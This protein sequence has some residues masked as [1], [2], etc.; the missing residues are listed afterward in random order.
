MDTQRKRVPQIVLPRG[1]GGRIT[2]VL[3]NRMHGDIY[4]IVAP[5]LALKPDDYLLE[6]ACGNG[7]FLKKHASHVRR[8]AGL[9]HS[10]LA[11]ETAIRNNKNRVEAG[12]AEF[13]EGDAARLPWADATFSAVVAMGSFV[14]F[15]KPLESIKEM[16]RVLR[17]GGRAVITL[18]FNA[19]DGRNHSRE[20][21]KWGMSL[22]SEADM[23]TMM[24]AAGFSEISVDY[25]KAGG[26]P[27]IMVLL[28]IKP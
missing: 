17:P 14:A 7:Y 3:M 9:D 8:V 15:T 10:P 2:F 27:N 25:A 18:E 11:I 23:R 5:V 19:E 22:L 12:T 6:V 20:V 16:Y 4:R 24:Q 1:L 28:G 13:V 21:Q 26:M